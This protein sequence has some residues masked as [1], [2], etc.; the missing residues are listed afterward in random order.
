MKS[1]LRK[2]MFRSNGSEKGAALIMAM[3]FLIFVTLTVVPL[4]TFSAA[5]IKAGK[6]YDDKAKTLY[7]ADAGIE[8]AKWQIRYD[9]LSG[10]FASYDPHDYSSTWSYCLPQSGGQPQINNRNVNIS[11]KNVWV[12][13]DISAPSTATANSIINSTKLMIIGGA[14]GTSSYNVTITYYPGAGENLLINTIGIWLPPGFSYKAGS[15]NLGFEPTTSGYQGGQA[16]VWNLS[17]L[18]FTSL[19]NVNTTDLPMTAKITFNYDPSTTIA[20]TSASPGNTTLHVSSTAGFK[21]TGTLLLPGEPSLVAYSGLT[22]NTFTGI[23]TSGIGSIMVGH[24]IGQSVVGPRMPDA[25]SWADTTNV[26][27][28]TF[29]WD[30]TV[31]LFCVNSIGDSIDT[32]LT[33]SAPVGNTVLNVE[34]TNG[35][36]SNGILTLPFEKESIKYTGKTSTS[37]TGIPASG[38]GSIKRAHASGEITAFDA[39]SIDTY[40]TKS[41]LRKVG[42]ALNGDYFAIGNSLMKDNDSNGTRETKVNSSAVVAAPN[43]AG[44]DNGIPDDAN[45][46]ASYLYWGTWYQNTTGKCTTVF[47]DNG[48]KFYSGGGNFDNGGAWSLYPWDSNFRAHYSSGVDSTRQLT[49]HNSLDLHNYS[50]SP[51]VTT[52]SWEQWVSDS[53]PLMPPN[54]DT[55]SNFNYWNRPGNS[56]WSTSSNTFRGHYSATTGFNRDLPL[57]YGIDLSSYQPNTVTITWDQWE[58]NIASGDGLNFE[59]SADGGVTWSAPI[60][61]FDYSDLAAGNIGT[62]AKTF[63]YTFSTSSYLTSNF[64]IQ[65]SVVGFSASSHYCYVDNISLNVPTPTYT[66]DDKLQFAISNDN[67]TTWSNYL[68]AFTGDK[69]GNSG[70]LSTATFQYNIPVTYLTNAFKVKLYISGFNEPGQYCNVDNVKVIVLNPDTGITFKIDNGSGAKIVYFDSSGNPA[71]STNPADQ[72]ISTRTQALLTY[73]YSSSSAPTFNGFAYSC[74]RD[75]TALAIKYAHQPVSP[76]TNFNGHA[77]YSAIGDLGDTGQQLSHAGWSLVNIFTG[78]ETLGHQLYLYDNYFG[79]RQNSGGVHVDWDGDGTAGGSI[80]DFVVPQQV[81]GEVN[82]AKLTCFVT[83][84][85]DQLTGDYLSLNGIKLWDGINSTSNSSSN[86]NNIWNGKSMVLGSNDGVDVDTP[87]INPTANPPQYITWNSAILTPGDTSAVI[88]LYTEQDYWFMI[89]MIISFRSEMTPGGS[90]NYLIHG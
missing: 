81:Q 28:L 89:Y 26:S 69:I 87:G 33:N 8:D 82:S 73:S 58:S 63:T 9:Q 11:L 10:K 43:P 78:P 54:A 64:K 12:P 46:A 51:Y 90:L 83:E 70:F 45:I 31:R 44:A 24:A 59:L 67:G 5:G 80:T 88:D 2:V 4:L 15:G 20:T 16:V 57:L 76:A 40:V 23:P 29:T 27:G 14:Y 17:A 47:T 53:N 35:F 48:S 61:A 1:R 84:G 74:F 19:P 56:S 37:F 68:T 13:K 77:T 72:V 66:S 39:T 34:N 30:D 86:P 79:S 60:K 38:T 41:E 55:C 25:I 32:S 62:T 22:T 6:K 49:E 3:V 50:A 65:F 42:G 75:V 85:D 18:P 52:L 7:T 71:N 36:P 21:P